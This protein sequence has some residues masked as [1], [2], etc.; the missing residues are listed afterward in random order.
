MVSELASKSPTPTPSADRPQITS[1]DSGYEFS[2]KHWL[3]VRELVEAEAPPEPM[4][5]L[6]KAS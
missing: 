2:L 3:E 5:T 6:A 4:K 1:Y